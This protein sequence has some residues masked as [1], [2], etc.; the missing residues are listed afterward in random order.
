MT[1]ETA[2]SGQQPELIAWEQDQ[3]QNSLF[4]LFSRL[5]SWMLLSS[6]QS[7]CAPAKDVSP[8]AL[9][10][11]SG[12]VAIPSVPTNSFS[13]CRTRYQERSSILLSQQHHIHTVLLRL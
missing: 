3:H 7:K 6:S 12:C 4:R 1:E 11:T 2:I 13:L 9:L 8:T 10:K 5:Y